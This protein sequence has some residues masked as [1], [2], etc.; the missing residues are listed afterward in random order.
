LARR[1][2]IVVEVWVKS[3]GVSDNQEQA[4]EA[5]I[6][7]AWF[8]KERRQQGNFKK[9][10]CSK[11]GMYTATLRRVDLIKNPPYKV[12]YPPLWKQS[13]GFTFKQL[14]PFSLLAWIKLTQPSKLSSL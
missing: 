12:S 1:I 6:A 4:G 2:P 9:A 14:P 13:V 10:E 5:R 7:N 8:T 3:L 11:L